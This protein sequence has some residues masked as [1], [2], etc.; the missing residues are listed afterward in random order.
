MA[1]FLDRSGP[2]DFRVH[3][4]RMLETLSDR[5]AEFPALS[6]LIRRGNDPTHDVPPDEPRIIIP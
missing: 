3:T 4:E 6:L 5:F 1:I 2:D